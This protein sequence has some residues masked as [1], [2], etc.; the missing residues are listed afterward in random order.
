MRALSSLPLALLLGCSSF[1]APSSID[2]YSITFDEPA[3]DVHNTWTFSA[4]TATLDG[5]A[6]EAGYSY[7]ADGSH[8][9]L[10]LDVQGDDVYEMTWSSA[11][12]GSCTESFE[13]SA[14]ANCTFTVE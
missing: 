11:D 8:S 7:S 14:P 4:D 13:G 2:G 9:T 12:G 1:A 5:G 3:N 10:T 6:V